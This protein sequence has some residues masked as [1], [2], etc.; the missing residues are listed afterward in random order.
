MPKD[1]KIGMFVGLLLVIG[2][3]MRLS[4]HPS[5]SARAIIPWAGKAETDQDIINQTNFAPNS[6]DSYPSITEAESEQ[7]EVK[8]AEGPT[9]HTVR[10]GETLSAISFLYY[11]SETKWQKILDANRNVI[12]D[13]KNL[14]P[15]TE[16]VIPE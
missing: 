4:M 13:V 8:F 9:Y 7:E 1:Y 3:T 11:G 5:L 10:N 2:A 15:G 14:K 12:K 6:R 16:L